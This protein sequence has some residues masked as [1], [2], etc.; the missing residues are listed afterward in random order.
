MFAALMVA[1]LREACQSAELL[2]KQNWRSTD[3][4][5]ACELPLAKAAEKVLASMHA[6]LGKT[7]K[8]REAEVTRLDKAKDS[9]LNEGKGAEAGIDQSKERHL[10][11]TKAAEVRVVR[12]VKD[13]LDPPDVER[14]KAQDLDVHLQDEA[15]AQP[16]ELGVVNAGVG[17]QGAVHLTQR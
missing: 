1:R 6:V 16:D 3:D 5:S 14:F 9:A 15:P 2:D 8:A 13:L 10:K 7:A 17:G 11:L 12:N 4:V